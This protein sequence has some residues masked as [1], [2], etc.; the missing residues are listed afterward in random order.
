MCERCGCRSAVPTD[1]ID[2]V[3]TVELTLERIDEPVKV[4]DRV[5]SIDGVREI[6]WNDSEI[7]IRHARSAQDDVQ[8]AVAETHT[9]SPR[10]M[11]H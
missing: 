8:R 1:D 7:T 6:R 10:A 9:P 4:A 5:K 3:D 2:V 11:V